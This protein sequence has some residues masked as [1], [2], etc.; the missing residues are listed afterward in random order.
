[1]N[2]RVQAVHV[3]SLNVCQGSATIKH[4][5]VTIRYLYKDLSTFSSL[6]VKIF[7]PCSRILAMKQRY[8]QC[9]PKKATL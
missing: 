9:V 3:C 1:M 6:V 5:D 2:M 7:W 4:S 8:L